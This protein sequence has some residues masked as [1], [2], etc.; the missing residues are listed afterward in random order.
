MIVLGMCSTLYNSAPEARSSTLSQQWRHAI[1]GITLIILAVGMILFEVFIRT[2]MYIGIWFGCVCLIPA[3]I[4][5]TLGF[6]KA[7]T[8][9]IVNL[10]TNSSCFFFSI[11]VVNYLARLKSIPPFLFINTCIYLCVLFIHTSLL[12]HELQWCHC[13]V[14]DDDE[15]RQNNEAKQRA[16]HN[17]VSNNAVAVE[18]PRGHTTSPPAY[19]I[20]CPDV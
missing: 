6:L 9:T 16:S 18:N 12:I 20:P 7:R 4:A 3:F 1:C 14:N 13:P 10:V 8:L 2:P 5:L 15:S 17:P 11:T 19:N